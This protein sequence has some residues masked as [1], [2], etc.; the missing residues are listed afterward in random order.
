MPTQRP[1]DKKRKQTE[2]QIFYNFMQIIQSYPQYTIPEHLSHLLRSK[3]D[4]EGSFFWS[5]DKLLKKIEDYKDELE[6][7]LA[8]E[9]SVLD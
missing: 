2:E 8:S 5:N 7:E 9:V 1:V 4:L 3:G 6:R